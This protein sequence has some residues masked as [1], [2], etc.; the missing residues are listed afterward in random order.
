MNFIPLRSPAVCQ[1][2]EG[3]RAALVPKQALRSSHSPGTH[4]SPAH[5]WLLA[6]AQDQNS[7]TG[8]CPQRR[9]PVST[10]QMRAR[11]AT[12]VHHEGGCDL[13]GGQQDL[14]QGWASQ[15]RCPAGTTTPAA[16]CPSAKSTSTAGS[17]Q[18]RTSLFCILTLPS[19]HPGRACPSYQNTQLAAAHGSCFAEM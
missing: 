11:R 6:A 14:G 17:W 9:V 2:S 19:L 18:Q 4:R 7:T 16:W 10:W 8:R 5:S 3:A 12:G 15:H 13:P 1:P